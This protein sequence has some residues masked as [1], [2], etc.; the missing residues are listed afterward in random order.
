VGAG[1]AA[2]MGCGDVHLHVRVWVL[3]LLQACFKELPQW[4]GV[5]TCVSV[6]IIYAT[7]NTEA[8]TAKH[9]RQSLVSRR[10]QHGSS[11]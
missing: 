4:Q 5:V 10:H 2:V 7:Y 6:F 11:D 1:A 3:V 8:N 9:R